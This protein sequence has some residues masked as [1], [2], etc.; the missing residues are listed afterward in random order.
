MEGWIKVYSS[1]Q[2]VQIEVA[3]SLLSENNIESVAI[4]K[5]DSVYIFGDVELYVKSG[6]EIYAMLI[7]S[8][9]EN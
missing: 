2:P 6:T 8:Q 7:L 4:S 9:L 1:D 5:K 3:K